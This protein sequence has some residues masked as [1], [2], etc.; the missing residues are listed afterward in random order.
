[1]VCP[2]QDDAAP[3]DVLGQRAQVGGRAREWRRWAATVA[4][5]LLATV[6]AWAAMAKIADP[7]AAVRAVRAYQLLPELL[8]R[9]VAWG[10]PFAE[11]ALAILLAAG[12]ATRGRSPLQLWGPIV[13][14]VVVAVA[15]IAFQSARS[16]R[17]VTQAVPA[18][19]LGPNGG[20]LLG[21]P[22]APVL[23][24]EYGDF[25]CPVCG[26]WER[27]VYPT[28]RRLVDQGRIRF[29]YH[30]IA[31][32][33]PESVAAANAAEAAGD[34]GRFWAYHDLLFAGQAPENSGALTTDRLLALGRQVGLTSPRFQQRVRDGTYDNWV[35]RVTDQSSQ[36]GVVQ[37]PTVLV[38]GR[39]IDAALTAQGLQA[40]VNAATSAGGN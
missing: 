36:Q 13:L 30:P 23:V 18:H 24:E 26:Q 11:L 20:E 15:G 17:H 28:V 5:L 16:N 12:L 10:L 33:G 7:D 14:L 4:R 1:M 40:A 21:R 31:F 2:G 38:N 25:Q 3:T 9:P 8:V 22:S 32:I 6:W 37:T 29:E 27:S 34:E 39:Q 35:R 19:A